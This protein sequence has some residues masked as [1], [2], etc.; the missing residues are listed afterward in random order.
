MTALSLTLTTI[1]GQQKRVHARWESTCANSGARVGNYATRRYGGGKYVGAS[2]MSS[3]Y[4]Y[5]SA[6]TMTGWWFLRN[7]YQ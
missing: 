4:F 3:V 6:G 2:D 1:P 7:N 5:P